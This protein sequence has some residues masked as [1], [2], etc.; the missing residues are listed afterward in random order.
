VADSLQFL[1]SGDVVGEKY[2]IVGTVGCGGM[3]V[4]YEAK[5]I[6]LGHRVAIK[7]LLPEL[8]QQ[9]E[10]VTRFDR[11]ARAAAQLQSLHATHVFDVDTLPDGT[12]YIVME[13]LQGRD[14]SEEL[15]ERG[16]LPIGVAVDYV[17]QACDAMAEAHRLGIVHRDLKPSNL[18]L[19]QNGHQSIVKVLDFGISKINDGHTPSLTTTRSGLGTAVYMSPEQVR[20]AKHVDARSDVWALGVVLYEMLT[21]CQPFF[22]DSSTAVL[23][24][25][26]ADSPE[27]LRRIREIVPAEL[28]RVVL[29]ALEKD[30]EKRFRDA[31]AFAAAIAPFA[32]R[33]SGDPAP[34]TVRDATPTLKSAPLEEASVRAPRP[35][36]T[37]APQPTAPGWTKP[38]AMKS[39]RPRALWV[40]GLFAAGVVLSLVVLSELFP[41]SRSATPGLLTQVLATPPPPTPSVAP[42]AAPPLTAPAQPPSE[43]PRTP[44]LEPSSTTPV[45]A[46]RP[47]DIKSRRS[48]V[49][50]P[51]SIAVEPKTAGSGATHD[52]SPAG[53]PPRK[54]ATRKNAAGL[55]D[56]PG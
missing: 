23:A 33:S 31:S 44:A 2:S 45:A 46:A 40:F 18:F 14:L 41:L 43:T 28:E 29:K 52:A 3:G 38:D 54:P 21:G 24:A 47:P 36:A 48:A 42:L 56:D 9:E 5:H 15:A 50:E 37:P 55:P 12:P 16:Q 39:A 19:V 32:S 34:R 35:P 4:V 13:F 17:L 8:A 30:R 22:G 25:I 6:R 10:A 49:V 7:M 20:D 53:P 51:R 26:I 1:S 27:P 11:E